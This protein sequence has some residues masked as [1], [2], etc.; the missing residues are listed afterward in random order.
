MKKYGTRTLPPGAVALDL[1][2]GRKRRT[3]GIVEPQAATV[4]SPEPWR[5]TGR[6]T[7]SSAVET[8]A[9]FVV[10]RFLPELIYSEQHSQATSLP[11]SLR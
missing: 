9:Y 4:Y 8:I 3:L 2:L 5:K 7:L 1:V 10:I 11:S 6:G